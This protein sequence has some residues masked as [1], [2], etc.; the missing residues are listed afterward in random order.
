[1]ITYYINEFCE[2]IIWNI[3]GKWQQNCIISCPNTS[4]NYQ[5]F[6]LNGQLPNG[7]NPM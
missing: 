7:Q 4:H 5:A 1:M 3:R 6:C 2:A